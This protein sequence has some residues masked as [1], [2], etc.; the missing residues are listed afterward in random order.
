MEQMV[1]VT[2]KTG[3]R[4]WHMLAPLPQRKE[5]RNPRV[6]F[7]DMQ[8]L[9]SGPSL[10]IAMSTTLIMHVLKNQSAFLLSFGIKIFVYHAN[11]T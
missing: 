11:D 8:S 6:C 7:E 4:C 10:T 5:K 1:S 2:A 9:Q 3:V